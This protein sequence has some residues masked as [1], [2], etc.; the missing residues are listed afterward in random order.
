VTGTRTTAIIVSGRERENLVVRARH[1]EV[2]LARAQEVPGSSADRELI[3]CRAVSK[4]IVA[5][6]PVLNA[7]VDL[8]GETP[9]QIGLYAYLAQDGRISNNGPSWRT[10]AYPQPLP[11]LGSRRGVAYASGCTVMRTAEC[12][13]RP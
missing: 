10:P 6:E 5:L 3:C 11:V 9:V 7:P 2:R 1:P 12:S 13:H 4:A 8:T